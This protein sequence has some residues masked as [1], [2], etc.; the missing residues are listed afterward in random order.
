MCQFNVVL[1]V[2]RYLRNRT[3]VYPF[4]GGFGLLNLQGINK[5]AFY[6]YKFMNEL[7]NN[8]LKNDDECSWVCKDDAGNI[9][10]L[11]WNYAFTLPEKMNDQDYY[12]QDLPSKSIGNVK[13]NP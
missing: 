7:G 2:Y 13:I 4:S 6:S 8:E 12:I 11:C 5:P 9:Q 10:I 3:I 1:G